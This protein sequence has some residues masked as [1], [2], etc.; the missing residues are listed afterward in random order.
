LV[1][2]GERKVKVGQEVLEG[3]RKIPL[4]RRD[5]TG[6]MFGHGDKGSC[7][8]PTRTKEQKK[9]RRREEESNELNVT[10]HRERRGKRRPEKKKGKNAEGEPAQGRSKSPTPETKARAVNQLGLRLLKQIAV[11]SVWGKRGGHLIKKGP[12]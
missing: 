7:I 8:L 3:K 2:R 11:P 4:R 6:Q 10:Q 12:N 5:T 9:K 1:E